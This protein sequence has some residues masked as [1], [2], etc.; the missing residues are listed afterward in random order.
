MQG[1][2]KK[3]S[4]LLLNNLQ[5]GLVSESEKLAL[6]EG[7]CTVHR[8][9]QT[10]R[11]V[12]EEPTE[13]SQLKNAGDLEELQSAL[14]ERDDLKIQVQPRMVTREAQT[15]SSAGQDYDIAALRSQIQSQARQLD[16][17]KK[18]IQLLH[19]KHT[20]TK[21]EENEKSSSERKGLQSL[22]PAPADVAEE[23]MGLRLPDGEHILLKMTGGDLEALRVSDGAHF[24][25]GGQHGPFEQHGASSRTGIRLPNG[26][27]HVL[28]RVARGLEGD[29]Q[30]EALRVGFD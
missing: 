7:G 15:I 26:A 3:K 1:T 20:R 2:K 5:N 30:V 22:A 16:D 18:L 27:G 23:R 25:S 9:Q 29:F 28:L 13:K 6:S 21:Q 10:E 17:Q 12:D 24:K 8:A 14:L 11:I 19:L 4:E